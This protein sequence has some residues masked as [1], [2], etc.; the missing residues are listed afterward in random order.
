MMLVVVRIHREENVL[1][2]DCHG[3]VLCAASL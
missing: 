1:G 2:E 3:A